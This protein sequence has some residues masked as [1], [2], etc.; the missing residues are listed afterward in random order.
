MGQRLRRLFAL[1]ERRTD[2]G[3]FVIPS[4]GADLIA[5]RQRRPAFVQIVLCCG[6]VAAGEQLERRLAVAGRG[7]RLHGCGGGGIAA[8]RRRLR[9]LA[10][11]GLL[12]LLSPAA[13]TEVELCHCATRRRQLRGRC[14][15]GG[16]GRPGAR[17]RRK[18]QQRG[19][20]QCRRQQCRWQRRHGRFHSIAMHFHTVPTLRLNTRCVISPRLFFSPANSP[21]RPPRQDFA[22]SQA[23]AAPHKPASG[24][25]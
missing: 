20:R 14:D 11:R 7:R 19:Q 8:E 9:T 10:G 18:S 15:R 4:G 1:L 17:C 3:R 12:L 13:E 24:R 2:R 21:P 25:T 22:D 16:V 6:L 23:S 5:G